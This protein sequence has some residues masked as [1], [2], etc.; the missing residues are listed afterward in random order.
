MINQERLQQLINNPN[1]GMESYAQL[2]GPFGT[3]KSNCLGTSLY[4]LDLY[5]ASRPLYASPDNFAKIQPGFFDVR[6][7]GKLLA[8]KYAFDKNY[9][10]HFGIRLNK[11]DMLMQYKIGAPFEIKNIEQ[12]IEEE[13]KGGK[14]SYMKNE[15]ISL[16][17][18]KKFSFGINK[19]VVDFKDVIIK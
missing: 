19:H 9:F 11:D 2:F 14:N 1:L 18:K 12:F 10:R 5:A 13:S 17:P 7:R 16:S 6:P 8:F 15:Y 4:V 3:F